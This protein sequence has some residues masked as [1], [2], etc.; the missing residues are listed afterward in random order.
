MLALHTTGGGGGDNVLLSRVG[1]SP[2]YIGW[3]KVSAPTCLL[4]M[5][6]LL[7]EA[8]GIAIILTD[9]LRVAS[10]LTSDV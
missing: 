9:R 3:N 10:S 4:W 5:S 8:S 1:A 6:F 2:R 7:I